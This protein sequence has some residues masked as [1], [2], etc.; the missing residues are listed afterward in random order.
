MIIVNL[1]V[2][3]SIASMNTHPYGSIEYYRDYFADIIGDVSGSDD[4]EQNRK[5]I[6]NVMAGFRMAIKE[7]IL[8]HDVSA[9][10][11]RELL[12]DLD[13]NFSM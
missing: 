13:T 8:Y 7:S 9:E 10:S 12:D 1:G 3:S 2:D 5:V 11:Y 6:A 4:I